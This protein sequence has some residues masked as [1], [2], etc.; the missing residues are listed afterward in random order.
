[1]ICWYVNYLR[2][3]H[4][5][6]F[7]KSAEWRG[8]P[9]RTHLRFICRNENATTATTSFPT[10]PW[11]RPSYRKGKSTGRAPDSP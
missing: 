3:A 8:G 9:S 11:R 2:H 1:M 6:V 10:N 7:N 4:N 5:N